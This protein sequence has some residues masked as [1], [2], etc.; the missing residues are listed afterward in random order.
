MERA[1]RVSTDE[2][3]VCGLSHAYDSYVSD[4]T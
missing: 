3:T 4:A 1:H 2:F